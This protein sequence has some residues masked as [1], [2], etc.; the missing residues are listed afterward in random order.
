MLSSAFGWAV[1]V[2]AAVETIFLVLLWVWLG[3][4]LAALVLLCLIG[5]I[6]GLC[7]GTIV[8]ARKLVIVPLR[9]QRAL[10]FPPGSPPA[11]CAEV[12]R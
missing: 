3:D 7:A 4:L 1:A 6:G 2:G 9:P 10:Q 11:A 8:F 12:Q 5:S